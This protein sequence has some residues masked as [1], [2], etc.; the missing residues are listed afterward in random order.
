MRGEIGI[1]HELQRKERSAADHAQTRAQVRPPHLH[2]SHQIS[3][4]LMALIPL[5]PRHSQA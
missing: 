2:H 1:M 3:H 4:L 5:N